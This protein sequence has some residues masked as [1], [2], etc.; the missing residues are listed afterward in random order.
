MVKNFTSIERAQST[1]KKESEAFR[2][3]LDSLDKK[4]A[5]Q[6]EELQYLH[7]EIQKISYDTG[8]LNK[9]KNLFS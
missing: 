1:F 7:E 6:R 5:M 9:I 3:E 2:E 4:V 8:F